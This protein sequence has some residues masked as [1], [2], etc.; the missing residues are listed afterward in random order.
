[1]DRSK[2]VTT[3]ELAKLMHVTKNTLFHYDQI[4]LF[5]PE[6]VTDNEYRY[7]S[8]QQLEVLDAIL[9]LKD[10]GMPLKEIRTFLEQR[11]PKRLLTLFEDEQTQIEKQIRHLKKQRQWIQYKSKK[12]QNCLQADMEVP[13]IKERPAMYYLIRSFSSESETIFVEKI[14]EL[15]ELYESRNHNIRYEIGYIQYERDIQK[16][17]YNNYQNVILLMQ[18]RPKDVMYSTFPKGEYLTMYFKGHWR[19]IGAAYEKMLTYAAE[20]HLTLAEQYL[21]TSEI[22]RLAVEREEE[23]VTE[24]SVQILGKS[25]KKAK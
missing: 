1:M 22:D 23:F 25:E 13:Y 19:G 20:H 8:L 24:I 18:Q 17:R 10:L 21:E 4:G 7:Y 6:I 5:S 14:A 9:L 12:L 3:G 2:Y 16:K 11:N 15:S